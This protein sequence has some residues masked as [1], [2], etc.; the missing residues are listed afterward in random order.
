MCCGGLG[1]SSVLPTSR[2]VLSARTGGLGSLPPEA[3]VLARARGRFRGGV[4]TASAPNSATNVAS[5]TLGA[6]AVARVLHMWCQNRVVP[7]RLSV[8]SIALPIPDV[9]TEGEAAVD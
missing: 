5:V 2:G 7:S 9:L 1:G 8:A 6:S 3:G 4:A